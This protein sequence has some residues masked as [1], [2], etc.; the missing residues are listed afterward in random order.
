MLRLP[1]FGPGFLEINLHGEED[2]SVSLSSVSNF[3]RDFNGLYVILRLTI[4]STYDYVSLDN[5]GY[6]VQNR[7]RLFVSQLSLASPFTLVTATE[8]SAIMVPVVWG[9]VQ[10]IDKIANI[11]LDREK[12]KLEIEKLKLEIAEK[13]GR[14]S[15]LD[16]LV[17]TPIASLPSSQ[18]LLPAPMPEELAPRDQ[19]GIFSREPGQAFIDTQRVFRKPS[20]VIITDPEDEEQI[21]DRIAARGGRPAYDRVT[22]RLR[23][24]P[25]QIE[26]IEIGIR[27]LPND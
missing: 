1:P 14:P 4:D 13:K 27:K 17:T 26:D 6:R 21:L 3:L 7:H 25:I 22:E 19:A 20:P 9:L 16:D 2:D 8:L 24:S 12:K 10:T 23:R 18:S 5:P 15:K 11:P